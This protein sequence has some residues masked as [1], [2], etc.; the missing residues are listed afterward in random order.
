[1]KKYLTI[2]ILC[3]N[4]AAISAQQKYEQQHEQVSVE[5]VIATK[6]GNGQVL[7]K[8]TLSV[9]SKTL[10]ANDILILTPVLIT[11][12]GSGQH[13]LSPIYAYG[14]TSALS[15]RRKR[16][17]AG[18]AKGEI[19]DD[20]RFSIHNGDTLVYSSIFAYQS[21]MRT[22]TLV[23]RSQHR[24]CCKEHELPVRVLYTC[25][26]KEEYPELQPR[27]VVPEQPPVTLGITERL[28]QIEHFVEPVGNYVPR[29]KIM[30]G[31]QEEAQI[32]YFK[33]DKIE[34]DSEYFDNEKV[35]RHVIDVTRQI[36]D[37][38]EAE[39]ARI[40]L[41]G[42]SSPEGRYAYNVK[43]AG[44]RCEAMKQYILNHIS[45]PDSCFKLV[46]GGEGWDELRYLIENSEMSDKEDILRIIDDVPILKGREVRLMKLNQGI[47]YRNMKEHFF[48]KLRRAGYIKVY[49]RMKK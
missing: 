44:L 43:L 16:N 40:V 34:I 2:L 28:A 3:F 7:L 13:A 8:F 5:N 15:A 38:P 41:L 27:I 30:V 32:I 21:W 1:M 39:I 23:M 20:T 49:Y 4:I 48:P 14:R 35:L 29:Q 22:A 24:N 18:R 36:H 42:L 11:N 37:D 10:G 9:P 17:F 19:T 31:E 45:L 47:P 25:S 46:N 12:D 6:D 26:F 33:W